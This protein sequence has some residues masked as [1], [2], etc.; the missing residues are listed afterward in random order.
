MLFDRV[1]KLIEGR[2]Q[3]PG[4]FLI[5][6]D[7]EQRRLFE[8]AVR[9]DHEHRAA[10]VPQPV[11]QGFR[12]GARGHGQAV[13][14]LV[15]REGAATQC[16]PRRREHFEAAGNPFGQLRRAERGPQRQQTQPIG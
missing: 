12:R 6:H 14:Y 1:G 8:H 15:S 7:V 4:R 16:L 11:R 10:R 9:V 13:P 3:T 5:E 2:V